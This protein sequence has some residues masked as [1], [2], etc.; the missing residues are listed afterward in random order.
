MNVRYLLSKVVP[1]PMRST[2][3]VHP[4]K[5]SDYPERSTWWQWRGRVYRYRPTR[6]A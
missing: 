1:V 2:Y 6:L 4:D 3:Q 5:G